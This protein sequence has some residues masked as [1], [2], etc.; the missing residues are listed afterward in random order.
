MHGRASAGSGHA[1]LSIHSILVVDIGYGDDWPACRVMD[2]DGQCCASTG[3]ESMFGIPVQLSGGQFPGIQHFILQ[4]GWNPLNT[5]IM[6]SNPSI[7]EIGI[8]SALDILRSCLSLK[9]LTRFHGAALP[10]P[11]VPG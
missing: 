5:V 11:D 2:G 9:F 8:L 6:N 7:L 4:G 10:D 1:S 3:G